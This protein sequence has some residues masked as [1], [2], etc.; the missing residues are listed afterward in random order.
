MKTKVGFIGSAYFLGW[1]STMLW[2]PRIS[3]M[4]GR[5]KFFMAAMAM[6]LLLYTMLLQCRSL[7][8][9]ILIMCCFGMVTSLRIQI[10]YIYLMELMP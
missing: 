10:G 5:K 4:N 9:M 1:C 6:D 7:E 8:K 3:D 2:L